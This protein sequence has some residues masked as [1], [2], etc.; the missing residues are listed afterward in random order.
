[1][2]YILEDQILKLRAVEP[3][4]LELFYSWENNT[5]IWQMSNTLVP[6][7]KYILRSYIQTSHIDIFQA[8]Q[9]RFMIDHKESGKTI[10][11]IDLFDYDPVNLRVGLGILI[12]LKEFRGKGLAL[13]SINLIKKYC[14]TSLNLHQI[15]CNISENNLES[16]NLF[17]KAGFKLSGIRNDWLLV[18]GKWVNDVIFQFINR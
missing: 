6:F 12:A 5:E 11:T 3:E 1:M 18:N 15:Y 17:K 2:N 10:G 9:F 8:K 16:Q 13:N 7:S 4:D 14:F